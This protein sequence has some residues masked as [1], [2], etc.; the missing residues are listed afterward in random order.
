VDARR[1]LR[2]RGAARAVWDKC[3]G[4]EQVVRLCP[5]RTTSAGAPSMANQGAHAKDGAR[6]PVVG[7]QGAEIVRL[8]N[9][10]NGGMSV[11]FCHR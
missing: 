3:P 10:G 8:R 9:I 5:D 6:C 4:I 11:T 7:G 1:V 2:D